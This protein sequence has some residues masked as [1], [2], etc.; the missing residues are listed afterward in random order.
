MADVFRPPDKIL[1]PL[2]EP[3][4]GAGV[5]V[6][7][8]YAGGS[9]DVYRDWPAYFGLTVV[10]V[11]YRGRFPDGL[12]DVLCDS[13]EQSA[14]EI[15][16][17]LEAHVKSGS[18]YFYGHSFGAFTAWLVA[19]QLQHRNSAVKV[20]HLFVGGQQS[21]Y[22][23]PNPRH[24]AMDV[25]EFGRKLAA[26]G[27]IPKDMGQRVEDPD[28]QRILGATKHEFAL[29]EEFEIDKLELTPPKLE[30]PVTAFFEAEDETHLTMEDVEPWANVSA[31]ADFDLI[32]IYGPHLFLLEENNES[33]LVDHIN[34]YL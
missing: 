30:C 9:C 8:P 2:G 16:A 24:R 20:R 31:V 7:F 18:V 1:R 26:M 6:C 15:A 10:G 28:V 13:I 17:A 34:N 27:Y 32:P 12:D 4:E 5:L 21:P 19:V 3:K 29:D 23:A 25:T 22:R 33:E 14:R 11:V